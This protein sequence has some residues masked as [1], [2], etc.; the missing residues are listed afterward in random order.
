MYKH[1][2]ILSS[3]YTLGARIVLDA[4]GNPV[5]FDSMLKSVVDAY[6]GKQVPFNT[7]MMVAEEDTW[8][9]VVRKD[10]YFEGV[11]L[12][13]TVEE[14]VDLIRKDRYLKGTDVARYI[15][16]R[17]RC[18]HARLEKMTYLAYA[19]Y[20]CSSGA[21]LFTDEIYAFAHG[22]V[23]DSVLKRYSRESRQ[24]PHMVLD[25]TDELSYGGSM[26]SIRSR[27]LFAEDGSD[28]LEAI[29]NVIK[30]FESVSTSDLVELTHTEGSPWQR[31]YKDNGL[32]VPIPDAV[33]AKYHSAESRNL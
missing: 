26:M 18:T 27:I 15:L 12:I 24:H 8:D 25:D 30:R 2:L 22:P 17:H 29:D 19:D 11:K 31:S 32:F 28:K 33:I 9:S 23:V 14:F 5:L 21:R 1:M 4:H 10:P 20:L 7:H 6:D 3:S 13:D 16:S